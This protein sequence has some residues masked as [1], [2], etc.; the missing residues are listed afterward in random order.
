MDRGIVEEAESRQDLLGQGGQHRD[1]A[2]RELMGART[3]GARLEMK[4]ERVG[5]RPTSSRGQDVKV[6]VL[7]VIREARSPVDARRR[8]ETGEELEDTRPPREDAVRAAAA[9]IVARA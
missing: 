9:A 4:N 1:S 2:P 6:K 7:E 5:G 3:G 8:P